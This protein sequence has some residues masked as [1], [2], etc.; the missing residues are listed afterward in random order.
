MRCRPGLQACVPVP[1]NELVQYKD[2]DPQWALHPGI[3]GACGKL[4]AALKDLT[5]PAKK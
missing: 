3:A 2:D 1:G 4:E 5:A